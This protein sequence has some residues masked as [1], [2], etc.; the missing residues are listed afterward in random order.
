MVGGGGRRAGGREPVDQGALAG[1]VA[2]G[3]GPRIVI[4]SHYHLD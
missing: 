1:V 2:T 4:P 3:Y